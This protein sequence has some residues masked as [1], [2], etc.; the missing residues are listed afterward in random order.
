MLKGLDKNGV[1]VL[2]AHV[3]AL[4]CGL[5][6]FVVLAVFGQAELA[7][8][9]IVPILMVIIGAFGAN[10]AHQQNKGGSSK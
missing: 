7:K 3:I 9:Y 1:L 4:I 8:D 6:A 2:G 5:A 10:S